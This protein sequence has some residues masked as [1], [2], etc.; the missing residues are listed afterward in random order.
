MSIKIRGRKIHYRF[1]VAGVDYSGIC[2]SCE[3][4]PD[5]S[6]QEISILKKRAKQ[7]EAAERSRI[8]SENEKLKEIERDIRKNKTVVAL[9]E[10]FKYELTGGH[11]IR[12]EEAFELASQKPAKRV[13]KS[14]Y[15]GLKKTYWQ[16]FCAYLTHTYPDMTDICHVRRMHCEAYVK[17]LTD[18]GRFQ[19]EIRYTVQSGQTSREISY[20]SHY[21]IS[22]KTIKEIVCVCR[23]VFTRLME[24]AGLIFNPWN[25]VVLPEE[26]CTSRKIYTPEEIN[27]IAD[28]ISGDLQRMRNVY[29]G[30][31]DQFDL[32][33]QYARFCRPLF[34]IGS[35]G[36]P[37]VDICLMTWNNIDWNARA[38][39]RNRSKTGAGM[40][41]FFT[42]DIEKLLR[43][44]PQTS[45]YVFPDHA[46]MYLR[47]SGCVSYRVIKFLK[48]L[49]ITTSVRIPERRAASIKDHH[50]LRHSYCTQANKAKIPVNIRMKLVGHKTVTMAEHYANHND[51]DDL[52]EAAQRLPSLLPVSSSAASSISSRN[53][54]A[55]LAYSLPPEIIEYILSMANPA[56]SS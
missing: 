41:L 11:P 43:S 19:K 38:I 32:W 39:I 7:I 6:A 40:I 15:A 37:E 18:N 9:V 5:A 23:G 36:W 17:Y 47:R 44:Q 45:Q 10:N 29:E 56:K 2:E 3:I 54:L 50:S 33:C 26:D 53:K 13:S 8:I 48:G 34:L 27:R 4:P 1:M 12:L 51:L 16:D 35:S 21:K 14:S 22:A 42:P 25:E 46:E 28:G 30:Q 52:R 49:G 31:I 20:S 24:D 55:N